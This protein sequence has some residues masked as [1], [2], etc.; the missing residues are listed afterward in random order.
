MKKVWKAIALIGMIGI[1]LGSFSFAACADEAKK[2]YFSATQWQE[3]AESPNN[4]KYYMISPTLTIRPYGEQGFAVEG[5]SQV[6]YAFQDS[7][8]QQLPFL[9]FKMGEQSVRYIRVTRREAYW[10]TQN[11]PEISLELAAGEQTVN[12]AKLL[13][14]HP[15]P[16]TGWVYVA[17]GVS[18]STDLPGDPG[19]LEYMY[20]SN[21]DETGA[22]YQKPTQPAVPQLDP[23]RE[24]RYQLQGYAADQVDEHGYGFL[25]ST[26]E[27]GKPNVQV[28]PAD[29]GI[30]LQRAEGFQEGLINIAWV[31]PYEQLSQT[32][33][34]VLDIGNDGRKDEGPRVRIYPYWEG[35]AGSSALFDAVPEEIGANSLH[36]VNRFP[37]KYAVDSV[38]ENLHGEI[39]V[40]MKI[41]CTDGTTLEPLVIRDAYL[42]G[43][44]EGA[45]PA[46]D[47]A[48]ASPEPGSQNG[49]P[50]GLIAGIAAAAAAVIIAAVV[51]IVRR[52]KA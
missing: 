22:V 11:A 47:T 29:K 28:T 42:L 23:S 2:V 27:D 37:L 45:G 40:S 48:S 21:T 35:I 9:H 10:V 16:N 4:G 20:F 25:L 19:Q 12:V 5:T 6:L 38:P 14:S 49:L 39:I 13:A 43:Y 1:V 18:E 50:V 34:L 51:F 36:G 7:F 32:P 52:K 26:G 46:G 8:L 3:Q 15:A 44:Q 31:V 33:Y 17:V 41:Q 24:I 30:T